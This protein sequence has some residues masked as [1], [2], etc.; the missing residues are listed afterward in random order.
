MLIYIAQQLHT[1]DNTLSHKAQC[2]KTK[3]VQLTYT[4]LNSPQLAETGHI[5]IAE[6]A[7]GLGLPVMLFIHAVIHSYNRRVPGGA[8]RGRRQPRALAA[9]LGRARDDLRAMLPAADA[10]AA[11]VFF[12]DTLAA[13]GKAPR[14]LRTRVLRYLGAALTCTCS[15]HKDRMT[16]RH[17]RG[18][19]DAGYA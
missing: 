11:G 14:R 10:A 3:Q 16:P 1:A 13:A 19:M 9:E 15:L 4:C 17:V 6:G 18:L 5:Q 7:I 2:L 12:C 8:R